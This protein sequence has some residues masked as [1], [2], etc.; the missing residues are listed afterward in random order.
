M[1]A[2]PVNKTQ[3][4][5]LLNTTARPAFNQTLPF[6]ILVTSAVDQEQMVVTAY[7]KVYTHGKGIVI[8]TLP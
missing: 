8:L 5:I 2:F 1:K 7:G 3:P 6:E 4:Y